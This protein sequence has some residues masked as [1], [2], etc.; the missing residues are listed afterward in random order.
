[1]TTKAQQRRRERFRLR[2]ISRR[3]L[4]RDPEASGK[5]RRLTACGQVATGGDVAVCR[6]RELHQ[7]DG[8]QTCGSV[9]SCPVCAARI[10]AERALVVN[11]ALE[12]WTS[13]DITAEKIADPP[14]RPDRGAALMTVTIPHTS[15]DSTEDMLGIVQDSWR[16][17]QQ[18][19][20]W[21]SVKDDLDLVGMIRS[22][23]ITY[24]QNGPHA[25]IH[26][27]VFF[28]RAVTP[29]DL[30]RAR[31]ILF[32]R[33]AHVVSKFHGRRPQSTGFDLQPVRV[34]DTS[35]VAGYL[36]KNDIGSE[37]TRH[38]MK[39]RKR[40]SRRRKPRFDSTATY[41]PFELLELAAHDERAAELWREYVDATHGRRSMSMS[42]DLRE[43]LGPDF[44]ELADLIDDDGYVD[45]DDEDQG[46]VVMR[47]PGEVYNRMTET[48]RLELLERL[49]REFAESKQ[50]LDGLEPVPRE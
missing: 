7:Y 43:A 18:G 29:A 23:E 47:I 15:K 2:G 33:W 36:V 37:I 31:G 30:N 6:L 28:D 46:E 14:S 16:R 26:A 13:G 40:N 50:R 20:A 45:F 12:L 24:G 21:Y 8:T 9:W 32:D 39:K 5:F 41:T 27:L 22:T 3:V 38:D 34:G 44:E 10:R 11:L 17:L 1:M 49:D 25:H 42:K 48:E 4:S 19:R 35:T